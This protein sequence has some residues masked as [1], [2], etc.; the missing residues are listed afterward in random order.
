MADTSDGQVISELRRIPKH[1]I[2]SRF[3]WRG[4]TVYRDS[5]IINACFFITLLFRLISKVRSN[6]R[7]FNYEYFIVNNPNEISIT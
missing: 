2:F 5:E 4:S 7:Q 6:K 3:Q 1:R